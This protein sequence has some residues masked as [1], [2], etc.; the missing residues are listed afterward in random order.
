MLFVFRGLVGVGEAS[1]STVAPT[2][3]ADYYP[4]ERR[5]RMLSI[6][7]LAIPIGR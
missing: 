6:F 4:V 2:I 1:Y 5:L 7:Y 3:I